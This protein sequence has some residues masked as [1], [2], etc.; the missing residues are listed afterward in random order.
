VEGC[1]PKFFNWNGELDSA[2][3][4]QSPLEGATTPSRKRFRQLRIEDLKSKKRINE[5]K[6]KNKI[7]NKKKVAQNA[8]I[9]GVAGQ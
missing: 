5:G 6:N 2:N 4:C 8:P 3:H 9:V 1:Y 7:K